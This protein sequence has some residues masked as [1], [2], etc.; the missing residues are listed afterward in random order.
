MN[1]AIWIVQFLLAAAF[2]M[3]G[4]SKVFG[5]YESGKEKMAYFEDFTPNQIKL[6]GTLELLGAMGLILPSVL[7]IL[8][9]LSPLAAVGLMIV[10]V[11]A[12]QTHL[13]RGENQMIVANAILFG[14]AAFVAY[15]RFIAEPLT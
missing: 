4:G 12:A 8:V 7:E 11:G 3:A 13:R 2:G 10:M 14:L 1:T 9:W 15:G 5:S 6:I